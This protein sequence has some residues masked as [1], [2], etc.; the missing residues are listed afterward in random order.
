MI[1]STTLRSSTYAPILEIRFCACQPELA[2]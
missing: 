1:V 2:E